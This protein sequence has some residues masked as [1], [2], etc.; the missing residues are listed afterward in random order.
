VC[1]VPLVGGSVHMSLSLLDLCL[2]T[3]KDEEDREGERE[4]GRER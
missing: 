2:W 1:V 4:R 3:Q